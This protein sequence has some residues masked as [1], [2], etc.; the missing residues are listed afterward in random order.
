MGERVN[1]AEGAKNLE[2]EGYAKLSL[3]LLKIVVALLVVILLI[4]CFAPHYK[5]R[6]LLVHYVDLYQEQGADAV[7]LS[8]LQDFRETYKGTEIYHFD[9]EKNAQFWDT[10]WDLRML[11]INERTPATD[12]ELWFAD[13]NITVRVSGVDQK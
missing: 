4:E 7:P 10:F 2:K 9:K 12:D 3:A 1:V 11:V 13:D 6:R 8:E 5:A